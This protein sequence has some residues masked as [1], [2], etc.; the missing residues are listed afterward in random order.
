MKNSDAAIKA[1]RDEILA[2][3]KENNESNTGQVVGL[4]LLAVGLLPIII[5]A[6]VLFGSFAEGFGK[7]F[8]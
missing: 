1:K 2:A 5:L 8:F 4:G 6:V 3:R 7:I